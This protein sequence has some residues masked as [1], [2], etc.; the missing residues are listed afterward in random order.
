MDTT[1]LIVQPIAIAAV[2]SSF[3]MVGCVV[4][5]LGCLKNNE[6]IG[7]GVALEDV[8]W[9]DEEVEIEVVKTEEE[10]DSEEPTYDEQVDDYVKAQKEKGV[11]FSAEQVEELKNVEQVC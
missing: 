7:R 1:S 9:G 8:D 6:W 2:F 4:G 5:W 11:S 3:F 10:F